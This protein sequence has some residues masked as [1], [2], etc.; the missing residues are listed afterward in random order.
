VAIKADMSI[1]LFLLLRIMELCGS[2]VV[3]TSNLEELRFNPREHEGVEKL[4]ELLEA[5]RARM[6]FWK[7]FTSATEM[8]K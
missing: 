3:R 4:R 2:F 6:P 1:Q 5:A 8:M 7:S